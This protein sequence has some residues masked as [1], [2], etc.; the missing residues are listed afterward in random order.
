MNQTMYGKLNHDKH[1]AILYNV[2]GM[3]EIEVK[4]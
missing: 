3:L 1:V 4:L 2:E